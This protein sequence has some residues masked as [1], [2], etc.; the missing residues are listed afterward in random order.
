MTVSEN[1]HERTC[2]D[3]CP[4]FANNTTYFTLLYN[5][6]Y[7]ILQSFCSLH[8]FSK[9]LSKILATEEEI[10]SAVDVD[11]LNIHCAIYSLFILHRS[12]KHNRTMINNSACDS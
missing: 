5:T 1:C 6:T 3:I 4:I 2:K 11:D 8:T 7:I 9:I 10:F 12:I